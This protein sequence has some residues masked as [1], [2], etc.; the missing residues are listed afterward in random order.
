M[1]GDKRCAAITGQGK[2]CRRAGIAS[3]SISKRKLCTQHLNLEADKAGK[4]VVEP[5]LAAKLPEPSDKLRA[6]VL[7]K[8]RRKLY[9]TAKDRGGRGVIYIYYI[10]NE[11]GLNY[12]KV[13]MTEKTADQRLSEWMAAHRTRILCKSFYAVKHSVKF[14]ERVIHLYLDYCRMHRTPTSDHTR[15]TLFRSV[16]SATGEVIDD[17]QNR[18]ISADATRLIAKHKHVEW[19]CAPIAEIKEIVEAIVAYGNS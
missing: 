2:P 4:K 8:L 17:D 1:E 12:W 14:V 18:V 19:F 15:E 16:W 5:W 3:S 11:T 7:A 10:A 13:G 9:N 6:A